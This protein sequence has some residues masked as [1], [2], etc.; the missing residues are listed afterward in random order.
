M[1]I[2]ELRN[3]QIFNK[4]H[5]NQQNYLLADFSFAAVVAWLGVGIALLF[6]SLLAALQP[7]PF[8]W[9]QFISL[10]DEFLFVGACLWAFFSLPGIARY[11]SWRA[12]VA[13]LKLLAD[14]VRRSVQ[15]VSAPSWLSLTQ[16]FEDYRHQICAYWRQLRQRQAQRPPN[17][18]G[19][20]RAP[21]ELFQRA[22][23]LLAP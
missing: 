21:L 18:W 11:L 19:N 6:I 23:L 12:L 13:S 1:T 10:S 9:T 4:E 22:A 2:T 3:K 16:L 17:L 5:I 15:V 20:G 14:R 8:L 7:T